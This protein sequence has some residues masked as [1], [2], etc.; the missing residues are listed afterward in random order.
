MPGPRP[1]AELCLKTAIENVHLI[2]SL[3]N[4]PTEY[5]SAI[6]RA[7]K[8]PTQLRALEENSDENI[9]DETPEHWKRMIK[10]EFPFLSAQ[11]NYVPKDRRSWHR[12]YEKYKTLQ[13]QQDA[14]AT[15]KLM[16]SLAAQKEKMDSRRS[17][18][19]SGQ[20]SRNL[21]LPKRRTT[22]WSQ[23]TETP[24]A[25][26]TFIQKARRQ[27]A[28]EATRFNLATPTG[29]L[30]V[31]A[32]QITKAPEAMINEARIKSQVKPGMIRAPQKRLAP[33]TADSE[34]ERKERETRLLRIKQAA[35]TE[36]AAPATVLSFSDDEDDGGFGHN[37]DS[38][39]NDLFGDP[40]PEKPQ[41]T[42]ASKPVKPRRGLLSAAPGANRIEGTKV[43]A[44]LASNSGTSA[45]ASASSPPPPAR[46]PIKSA[47]PTSVSHQPLASS[48]S[49]PPPS[50]AGSSASPPPQAPV[51]VKRSKPVDIFMR[52]NKRPR[53]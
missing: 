1:L 52:P 27:V 25:K 11:H 33:P 6:L 22:H 42:K 46:A 3:S 49:P 15:E 14:A 43:S 17:T 24:R 51:L 39:H 53:H 35:A 31:T 10:K 30:P 20:E 36:P 50:T 38:N 7:V 5:I 26:Q 29:R 48:A 28:V 4:M 2:T 9:Y 37:D 8:T 23:K 45:K 21:P 44:S 13:T 18:I 19:I 40:K 34:R 12:V 41:P 47:P 16:Q 32:G